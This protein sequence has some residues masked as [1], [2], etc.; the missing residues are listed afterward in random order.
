MD[1]RFIIQVGFYGHTKK[2]ELDSRRQQQ[3]SHLHMERRKG[4]CIMLFT[5]MLS[6]SMPLSH[7]MLMA[8]F[9]K[10]VFMSFTRTIGLT[11]HN[12]VGA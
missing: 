9:T 4:K 10:Y 3:E 8:L 2:E 11:A 6:R 12:E 7:L 1:F 5:F